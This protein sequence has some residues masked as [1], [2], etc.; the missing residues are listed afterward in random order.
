[1]VILYIKLLR[2]YTPTS[3]KLNPAY[4]RD[5]N[6]ILV[7]FSTWEMTAFWV[8]VNGATWNVEMHSYVTCAY[9]AIFG[10]VVYCTVIGTETQN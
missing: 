4:A 8:Y 3:L 6:K 9:L 1:M 10:D 7:A 5:R 2:T